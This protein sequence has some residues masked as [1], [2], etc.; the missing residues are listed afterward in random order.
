MDKAHIGESSSTSPCEET[1]S[2][3]QDNAQKDIGQPSS[4]NRGAPPLQAHAAMFLACLFWG[5]MAPLG[6]DA[7][8]H[9]ID[10]ITM[11]SLRVRPSS[12]WYATNVALPSDLASLRPSMPAS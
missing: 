5:L 9:G 7:M 11:V 10:G 2:V 8:S 1:H 6:K 12:D 4:S 3:M